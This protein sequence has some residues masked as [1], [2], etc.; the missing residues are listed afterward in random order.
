MYMFRYRRAKECKACVVNHTNSCATNISIAQPRNAP[1][2][3][4]REKAIKAVEDGKEVPTFVPNQNTSQDSYFY[5]AGFGN[6][7]GSN[8][9][10]STLSQPVKT[11]LSNIVNGNIFKQ[12]TAWANGYITNSQAN[13]ESNTGSMGRLERLK[14]NAISGD[15][16]ICRPIVLGQTNYLHLAESNLLSGYLKPTICS[17]YGGIIPNPCLNNT[18][19][20]GSINSCEKDIILL[21]FTLLAFT[22]AKATNKFLIIWRR[23]TGLN[24][25]LVPSF[26]SVTISGKKSS[27]NQDTSVTL[28]LSNTVDGL[29]LG[30]PPPSL[31]NENT[32]TAEWDAALDPSVLIVKDILLGGNNGKKVV[33]RLN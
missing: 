24:S 22:I 9:K 26:T 6:P 5:S 12:G 18:N 14:A 8:R 23:K 4:N 15:R 20:F 13:L 27:N 16:E 28:D 25:N 19:L 29:V 7:N 32:I 3:P 31:P 10:L 2:R 21:N 17:S 30:P 11:K 1:P 33:F